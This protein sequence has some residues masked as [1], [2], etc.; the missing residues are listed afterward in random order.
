MF[1]EWRKLGDAMWGLASLVM[2]KNDQ[3]SDK[4]GVFWDGGTQSVGAC[5][6]SVSSVVS[7]AVNITSLWEEG[8]LHTCVLWHCFPVSQSWRLSMQSHLLVS[9]FW[10]F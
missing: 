4:H 9:L 7:L 10:D 8:S 6:T 1:V 2:L 5:K 3:E